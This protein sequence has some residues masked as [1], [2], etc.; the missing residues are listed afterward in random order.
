MADALAVFSAPVA[1]VEFGYSPLIYA[2][3]GFTLDE[4]GQMLYRLFEKLIYILYLDFV[5]HPMTALTHAGHA[6]RTDVIVECEV[7]V[8]EA[9]A[10]L[11]APAACASR[12]R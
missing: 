9:E 2:E 7:E 6:P 12:G 10:E 11:S 1:G 4:T 8:G 3:C 5:I